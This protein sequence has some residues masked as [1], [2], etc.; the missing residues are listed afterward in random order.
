MTTKELSL[1]WLD[2]AKNDY[3]MSNI[4]LEKDMLLYSAYH[5]QQSLEET[6]E[7]L[8]I[9]AGEI[10]KCLEQKTK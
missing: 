3:K 9:E 8:I 2:I 4:A 5:L 7:K 10:I 1:K 6:L